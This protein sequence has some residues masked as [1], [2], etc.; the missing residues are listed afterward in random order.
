MKITDFD[1]LLPQHL[2]AQRPLTDRSGSRLLVLHRDGSIEH[3]RFIDLPSY[4][5]K[6]D[7]L[8]INNTKVFPARLSAYNQDGRKT[9]ILLVRKKDDTSW[10]VLSKGGITGRLRISDELQVELHNGNTAQ[11]ICSGNF[12]DIIWKY[13][14]M[15]LPPYM[16]RLPD[17]S[18]KISYQTVFAKEEGSIA[19]PTAGLHF[20]DM[21]LN[22]ITKREIR[23]REITLHVGI[24]TFKPIRTESVDEHSMD[25][26]SFEIDKRL[27]SEINDTKAS[28]KRVVCVGTTTTRAL[29]GYISGN[30]HVKSYNGRLKGMTDIFI[31]PGYD[32]QNSRFTHNQFSSAQIYPSD[33]GF[34]PLWLEKSGKS[35]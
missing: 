28:G 29:E 32:F 22:D 26:E 16:K 11:F 24:G 6:G 12:M 3:K 9:D 23:I 14:A 5:G 17:E 19:A 2:I 27:I 4:L 20:T 34:R 7:M 25:A 35:L 21:L 30:C 10:E 18:D 33:A 31:Y 13:G 15:P 1:Y 8:L